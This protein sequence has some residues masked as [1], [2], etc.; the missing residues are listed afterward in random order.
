[1]ISPA[2]RKFLGVKED[3]PFDYLFIT[4]PE[5]A[6]LNAAVY[7]WIQDNFA[8]G[9]LV[10]W[11]NGDVILQINEAGKGILNNTLFDA[12]I[13]THGATMRGDVCVAVEVNTTTLTADVPEGYSPNGQ[14]YDA[15]GVVVRQKTV[16]ELMICVK[17][18]EGKSLILCSER[19]N[20]KNG[21]NLQHEELL[22]FRTQFPAYYVFTKEQRSTWETDNIIS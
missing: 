8:R 17:G 21:T 3:Q 18:T 9:C 5:A 13:D 20:G 4:M 12:A 16:E 14:I 22:R 2:I 15:E 11:N 10:H 1:M 7:T 19:T 6:V